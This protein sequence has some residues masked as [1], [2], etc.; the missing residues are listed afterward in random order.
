LSA[1]IGDVK[2]SRDALAERRIARSES[3]KRSVTLGGVRCGE[4]ESSSLGVVTTRSA[5]NRTRAASI[6]VSPASEIGAPSS[7]S[8]ADVTTARASCDPFDNADSATDDDDVDDVPSSRTVVFAVFAGAT[9][10]L[11]P[12][13]SDR[14]SSASRYVNNFA[15]VVVILVILVL[16]RLSDDDDDAVRYGCASVHRRLNVDSDDSRHF[17]TSRLVSAASL[18]AAVSNFSSVPSRRNASTKSDTNPSRSFSPS[19]SI[20]RVVSAF[21][22]VV[23]VVVASSSRRFASRRAFR[24]ENNHDG[25]APSTRSPRR[26]TTRATTMYARCLDRLASL[27]LVPSR[28]DVRR[29]KSAPRRRFEAPRARAAPSISPI[30]TRRGPPR[31]ETLRYVGFR[32]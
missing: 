1:S 11:D 30:T 16:V 10:P 29:A 9:T 3:F 4:S 2:S 12:S 21:P 15:V 31:G 23:V 25:I 26:S 13:A 22:V 7:P 14:F 24:D 17:S 18:R 19:S 8:H 20:E 28:R 5:L 27:A 6:V 32:V